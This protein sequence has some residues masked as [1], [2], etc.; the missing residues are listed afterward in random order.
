MEKKNRFSRFDLHR[1]SGFWLVIIL[2]VS[3]SVLAIFLTTTSSCME[4]VLGENQTPIT[5]KYINKGIKI[6]RHGYYVRF[7][8]KGQEYRTSISKKEYQD[9]EQSIMP[10]VYLCERYDIAFT[11]FEYGKRKFYA[12]YTRWLAIL[13]STGLLVVVMRKI[14]KITAHNKNAEK[15]LSI[16]KEAGEPMHICDLAKAIGVENRELEKIISSMRYAHAVRA[17]KGSFWQLR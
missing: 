4:Q 7:D 5:Y 17:L 2:I 10:K 15:I 3:F 16:M 1:K 14:N 11:Y 12:K 6:R 13:I 8:Y 9:I